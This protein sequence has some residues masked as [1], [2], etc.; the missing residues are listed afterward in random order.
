MVILFLKKAL[1][2]KVLG[3]FISRNPARLLTKSD[4]DYLLPANLN[5]TYHSFFLLCKEVENPYLFVLLLREALSLFLLPFTGSDVATN[6]RIFC[7]KFY[8][9]KI[10]D[11]YVRFY[12]FFISA[13]PPMKFI[14]AISPTFITVFHQNIL[15]HLKILSVKE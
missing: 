7:Q 3:L 15:V 12:I 2:Q 13:T 6:L 11:S 5:P 14:L 10:E 8:S 9:Q 4:V 1:L